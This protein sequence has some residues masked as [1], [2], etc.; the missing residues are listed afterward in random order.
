MSEMQQK[1]GNQAA[2]SK[3]S[4]DLGSTVCKIRRAYLLLN[5]SES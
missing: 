1:N 3:F 5:K 2:V 4:Q